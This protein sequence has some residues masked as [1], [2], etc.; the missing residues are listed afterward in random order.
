MG[1]MTLNS[2]THGGRNNRFSK[3][4]RIWALQPHLP[5]FR[6]W[7]PHSPSVNPFCPSLLSSKNWDMTLCTSQRYHEN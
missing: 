6:F 4:L 7:L 1:S 5:E 2:Q 3:E